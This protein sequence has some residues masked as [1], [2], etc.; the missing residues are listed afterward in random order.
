VVVL[1]HAEPF[2]LKITGWKDTF[3]W[4]TDEVALTALM[5]GA[6]TVIDTESGVW[7]LTIPVLWVPTTPVEA[8]AIPVV[9]ISIAA[10]MADA[11]TSLIAR[12]M[13]MALISAPPVPGGRPVRSAGE[14]VRKAG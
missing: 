10:P 5:V 6:A 8:F 12:F 3:W 1:A 2:H 11:A 4:S 13:M 14:E 9:P 7:Q